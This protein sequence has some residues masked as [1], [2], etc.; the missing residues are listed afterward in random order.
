MQLRYRKLE[1]ST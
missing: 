1:I